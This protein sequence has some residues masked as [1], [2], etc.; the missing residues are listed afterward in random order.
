MYKPRR[1]PQV[2]AAFLLGAVVACSNSSDNSASTATD[3]PTRLRTPVTGT[4]FSYP[5]RNQL[6]LCLPDLPT[7]T[8]PDSPWINGDWITTSEIPY[9]EGAVNWESELTVTMTDTHRILKGNGL[10]NHATGT[11]PVEEGTGA[12][13]YY[14]A[15][16]ATGYDNASQIPIAAYDIDIR[17]PRNPQMHHQPVCVP[18]IFLGVATQTGA[19]WHADVAFDSENNLLDPVAALPMD[20]CWGHP[21]EKQY[22]YHGYSW[23]CFPNQG[24]PT[25]HSPLFGYAI[26]G[27]GVFGP[28]GENGELVTNDDLDECHGHIHDIEWDGEIRSMFHYHV[29][30]EYPY[31]IGCYRG[32][33][34]DLALHLQ[35]RPH[36]WKPRDPKDQWLRDDIDIQHHPADASH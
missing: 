25:Q 6:F 10:P 36:G 19:A 30:N 15:L 3:E 14:A 18:Y 34:V 20:E 5:A 33:P 4:T 28:R 12:Y 35:H 22:H 24:D 21:Y 16:P 31:S 11:F 7:M 2:I 13:P 26:D 27:F 23:K 17:M 8:R 29:N 32:V 9:V 1:F